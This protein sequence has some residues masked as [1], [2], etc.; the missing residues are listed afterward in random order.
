MSTVHGTPQD[1]FANPYAA[2]KTIRSPRGGHSTG[3]PVLRGQ[4][5]EAGSEE[6][7]TVVTHRASVPAAGISE[8]LDS[9]GVASCL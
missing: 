6:R 9:A 2:S 1:R 8:R 5:I 4:G 7:E 3:E